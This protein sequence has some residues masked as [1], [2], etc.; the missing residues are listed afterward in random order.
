[1]NDKHNRVALLIIFVFVIFA[2]VVAQNKSLMADEAKHYK[3]GMNILNGDSDRFDD[4]KMPVSALNALPAKLA[5][6]FLPDGQLKVYVEKI[7]AARFVTILIAALAAYMVFA[8][9]RELY[10]AA[11]AFIALTLFVLDPNIIAHSEF[12]ATDIPMLAA[13]LFSCYWFWKFA[14]ALYHR[15]HGERGDL[16]KDAVFPVN[17]VVKIKGFWI[18]AIVL[19]L[20][21]L[22][23]YTAISLYPIFFVTLF[24][25]I[26]QRER[27]WTSA[28]KQ[29]FVS[30]LIAGVAGIIIVNVGFLFNKTF[31]AF[32]DYQFH[33]D[34]FKSMQA[35]FAFLDVVPMPVPYPFLEGLDWITHREATGEGYG[36][37]YMLGVVHPVEGFYGYYI[38]ASLLKVPIASQILIWTALVVYCIKLWNSPKTSAVSGF[39][40][41]E[42]FL[43]APVL[44]YTIHFNFFYNAQLGFRF[45]MIVFPLLYVFTGSLFRDWTKFT[46]RQKTGVYALGAYLLV[47]VLS[48]Y[49]HYIPYF[50]ELM[51][52]RKMAYKYLADSNIDWEQN[53]YY[54]AEYVKAHPEAIVSPQNKIT[55]GL[56]VV[57]AN[58]LVG[59]TQNPKMY[60]WLRENFEPVDTVAY[61]Y[62]VYKI[63]PEDI[64]RLC[65]TTE[66]C[67]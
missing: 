25:Y 55:S 14:S 21:Q 58:D 12:V 13:L 39:F 23:K 35:D 17:S 7:F 36:N 41:N 56:I 34:K 38:L 60:Q 47:S 65:A 61:G 33:S 22:A 62:L 46:V 51:W 49:P 26:F 1:M 2:S 16:K 48:Y 15:E 64:D 18:F 28:L 50:N 67:Q 66:Y 19:G 31:T 24:V 20:A 42:M 53:K 29:A 9:T 4:S 32:G 57:D 52:D 44:V 59:V 40:E 6:M 8:W 45:Y 11:S 63:T 54:L 43:L 30:I 27:S 10:G 37:L 3:Y 5:D